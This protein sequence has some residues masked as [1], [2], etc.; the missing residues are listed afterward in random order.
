[1]ENEITIVFLSYEYN[2]NITYMNLQIYL[3]KYISLYLNIYAYIKGI[4]CD[5]LFYIYVSKLSSI[6]LIN[7]V[8]II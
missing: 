1:M 7:L 8:Q 6:I 5:T 4:H 3:I 2:M